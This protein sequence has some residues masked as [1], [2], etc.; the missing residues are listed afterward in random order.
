MS[1]RH[2]RLRETAIRLAPLI[3]VAA[4]GAIERFNVIFYLRIGEVLVK[5]A[6]GIALVKLGVGAWGPIS[7]FTFGAFLVLV[8]S[9]Y[10][11][12]RDAISTWRDRRQAW[13][14]SAVTDRR[15][16]GSARG[17]IGIQAGTAIIAGL[18][19]I[20]ASVMLS[21]KPELATYQVVQVLGRIPFCIASSLAVIVFLRMV[22]MRGAES[23]TVAESLRVWVRVCGAA[24]VI[25][26][27]LPNPIL[28]HIIPARYGD[29][30][31]LLPWASL[32][33]FSIGGINLVTTYWQATGRS[34]DAVRTLTYMCVASGI[35]DVL[36]VRD[37]DVLHL[38]YSAAAIT[39]AGLVG[40]LILV[41]MD[42]SH[43]LRGFLRQVAI[44]GVPGA[45]LLFLRG[46]LVIWAAVMVL[47]VAIPAL[48]SLYLYGLTLA[49]PD[50]PRVL[51]LAFEDPYRPGSG[52]GSVRTFEIDKRLA[53][54]FRVTV[55]C[56][57][58]P[59]SKPR[60]ED[61]VRYVHIGLPWGLKL[62]LMSYFIFLP[63]ALMRYPSELVVEDFAAPFSSVAVPWLTNRPVIGVVQWLF[64]QQKASEY[65]LPFHL[66]EKIGLSSHRNL[67]AVSDDLGA[68]LQRRNPRAEV[69]VIQNG[70]PDEA[71]LTHDQTRKNIL[72][73]GRLEIAQKGVDLLLEIFAA[74]ADH[75]DRM[76]TIAG[77][78]PD[79]E[80]IRGLVN[81]LGIADRVVFTGHIAPGDR[82]ELLASAE[83]V[84]MPSRYETFGMVAAEAL[85]VGTPV[86]AFD[87]PCLRSIL[88]PSSGVLVPAFDT[89]AFAGALMRI[90][91]DHW[92]RDRLGSSGRARVDHLRWDGVAAVQRDLYSRILVSS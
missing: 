51:H 45:A 88:S 57:R 91:D 16:W 73:L 34:S 1:G 11:M 40:L 48:R 76:L 6:A 56:A 17:I 50:R 13:I 67:V 77:S 65:R 43:S 35:C 9:A 33:G 85:A 21:G 84:A 63:W 92:L 66:V 30:Y 12:R 69:S 81:S 31:V 27:T 75:T 60:V 64:A 72:Y 3:V 44:V 49:S 4:T 61:G 24:A 53:R 82:F 14:R 86:V 68:E 25:V 80:R 52:G 20:I 47:G 59:G 37:G 78:G 87:I 46:H 7:G 19:L 39:T 71:F 41:K 2:R 38:A 15:P 58:Y 22:R 83:V 54:N 5:L 10:Y 8:V 42:W 90:L 36:A 74:I 26:A 28:S 70:L 89:E 29:V 79:E 62:S 18:D 55:V 32:I 23:A